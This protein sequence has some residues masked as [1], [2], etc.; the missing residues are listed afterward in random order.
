MK[1]SETLI[2]ID[3]EMTG[4]SPE[5]DVIIEIATVITDNQLQLVAEGPCLVIK[6]PDSIVDAMDAWNTKYHTQ[7]GLIDQVKQSTISL[8]E[9][10]Q[11]TIDFLRDYCNPQTSPFCGNCVY[12]DRA[13]LR[14]YM[15]ALD[16]FGN[17]R[18]VDVSTIKEV[19]RR[20]Y[21]ENVNTRYRKHEKHRALE[22]VYASIEELKHYKHYFFIEYIY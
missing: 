6:Q 13:F 7:S 11:K 22:D 2:W 16:S 3:L 17:Y 5:R 12:Q 19:L 9:A 14:R 4:L 20:W 15:P 21:P 18:I 8:E 10:E 1:P